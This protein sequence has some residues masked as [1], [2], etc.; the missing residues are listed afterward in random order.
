MK[1]P[2]PHNLV[3]HVA[4]FAAAQVAWLV[5]LVLWVYRT[6]S[7]RMMLKRVEGEALPSLFNGTL[8]LVTLI[9]GIAL[10]I[11][12]SVGLGLI[13]RRLTVEIRFTQLVD[14]FIAG[15]THELK[16]PLATIQ[17]Y[18]ETLQFRDVPKEETDQFL[19]R[20]LDETHRLRARIDQLL[21][22]SAFSHKGAAQ[23]KHP[24]PATETLTALIQEAGAARHLDPGALSIMGACPGFIAV[25]HDALRIVFDNLLD[26]AIKYSPEAVR[27]E[28]SIAERKGK[29]TL[30]FRD[31]GA[32][33]AKEDLK[34][35]FDKF[36]R[37]TRPHLPS[38][39]GTG[40]GLYWARLIMSYHG[41]RIKAQS[42]GV[43]KGSTFLLE[44]PLARPQVK[45]EEDR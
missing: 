36:R 38:V 43:G 13:F 4:L 26:N 27:V 29:L 16:T 11:A 6:V 32:G 5:L 34:T 1:R 21:Q 9:A 20:M 35:I 22:A 42:D 24:T 18:L 23:H 10:F 28:V 39:R 30:A 33:I 45:S 25:D 12:V 3:T 15:I 37:V 17:L 31:H 44:L 2:D 40:L 14:E 7:T 41:G 8:D 19:H